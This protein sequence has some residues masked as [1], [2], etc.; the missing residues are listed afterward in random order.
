M[1]AETLRVGAGRQEGATLEA[2]AAELAAHGL[3]AVEIDRLLD[4]DVRPTV[5]SVDS[6]GRGGMASPQLLFG[7]LLLIGGLALLLGGW[8]RGVVLLLAGVGRIATAWGVERPSPARQDEAR[9]AMIELALDESQKRCA[10]HSEYAAMGTC[11]RCGCFCCA[12]CM[13]GRGFGGGRVCMKCQAL[14]ELQSA[15]RRSASRGAAL[16]LLSGPA[17]IVALLALQR[18][19]TAQRE[20][21]AQMLA[22]LVG[23]S[24]PWLL[25]AALQA[26]ARS[27][28]P[29]V[30]SVVP[31]LFVEFSFL[32]GPGLVPATLW[33]VPLAFAF[34]GWVSTRQ[35]ALGEPAFIIETGPPA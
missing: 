19:I 31:W 25:L 11:P 33:F 34:Y 24:A 4:R 23:A 7:V 1:A 2:L 5:E 27:G 6:I 32:L 13:P 18:V 10:L 16:T 30:A 9:H 3:G 12:L 26:N 22:I 14:P 29:V 28:W 17:T 20:P 35:A 15:R 21:P 8:V